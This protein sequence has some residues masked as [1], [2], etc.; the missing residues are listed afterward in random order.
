MRTTTVCVLLAVLVSSLTASAFTN[1]PEV[2][3]NSIYRSCGTYLYDQNKVTRSDAYKKASPDEQSAMLEAEFTD[4]RLECYELEFLKASAWL[5]GTG[6]AGWLASRYFNFQNPAAMQGLFWVVNIMSTVIL[7]FSHFI[8]T[9]ISSI[10]SM[11]T[12]IRSPDETDALAKYERE[13]VR[14]KPHLPKELQDTLENNF[15]EARSPSQA[16]TNNGRS[17]TKSPIDFARQVLSLPT[18]KKEYK[19]DPEKLKT[20]LST[21]DE[22]VFKQFKRFAAR[23]V[24]AS[25]G[26][27]A[28]KIVAYF[29]GPPGVGKTTA[30]EAFAL[31]LEAPFFLIKVGELTV[32]ELEG[33][34][35]NPGLLL[36]AIMFAK[37]NGIGAKNMV[38]FFDELDQASGV[39]DDIYLSTNK[40]GSSGHGS[41][42]MG[43]LLTLLEPGTTRFYFRYLGA[44]LDIQDIIFIAAGNSN[45]EQE[46]Q[47]TN[48]KKRA[49]QDRF[50]IIH[51]DGYSPERKWEIVDRKIFGDLIKTYEESETKIHRSDF[52]TGE[53]DAIKALVL[54]DKEPGFREVLRQLANVIDDK[55]LCQIHGECDDINKTLGL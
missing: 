19:Y 41:G 26:V 15:I 6:A 35:N 5:L 55:A 1:G 24:A 32:A 28:K 16:Q 48:S 4:R 42:I 27:T 21:F 45:W 23:T 46:L 31:S 20:H 2:Q 9:Q 25:T 49:F 52:S 33:D 13:Y 50:E 11:I 38:I 10:K 12:A 36:Q 3:A 40:F 30:A 43:S 53:I 39:A 51:F 14:K 54:K 7:E 22:S 17:G 47:V 44:Y 37:F 34:E 29:Q 8:R 18:T